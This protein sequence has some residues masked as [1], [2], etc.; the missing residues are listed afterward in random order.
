M[1]YL[2]LD[3]GGE[4]LVIVVRMLV[5]SFTPTDAATPKGNTPSR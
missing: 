5:V 2:Y 3:V 4:L 1:E